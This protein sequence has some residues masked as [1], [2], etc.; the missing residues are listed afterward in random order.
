MAK[1]LADRITELEGLISKTQEISGG[2]DTLDLIE[3]QDEL[4]KCRLKATNIELDKNAAE[5]VAAMQSLNEAIAMIKKVNEKIEEITTGINT[6]NN[7]IEVVNVA[8]QAVP[9]KP[10]TTAKT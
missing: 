10:S 8:L 3:L 5:Y 1:E 6:C 9:P 4:T 7:A 2:K